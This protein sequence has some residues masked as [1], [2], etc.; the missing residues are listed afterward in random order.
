MDYIVYDTEFNQP[1]PKLYNPKSRFKP[2]R[3]CPFEIIEIGAVK[4]NSDLEIVDNFY[5]LIKPVIY[6]RL[7]PIVM[8]K[9]GIRPHELENGCSFKY[10]I[11]DFRSFCGSD[12]MLCTWSSNDADILRKNCIYHNVDTSWVSHHY[13]IQKHCSRFLN[14]PKNETISLKNALTVFDIKVDGK[15]HRAYK[16]AAYTAKVFI[17]LHKCLSH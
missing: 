10:A 6:K 2:N 12:F 16:D 11:E 13:D 15:L 3:I 1:Q 8:R 4:V 14:L 9:T 5:R 7:S 17:K